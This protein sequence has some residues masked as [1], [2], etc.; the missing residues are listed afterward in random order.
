VGLDDA[1]EESAAY[2]TELTVNGSG[3]STNVIPAACRVVGERR[4]GV[5]EVGDC[6]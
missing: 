5:L 3:G 2:E 4:I 1:V 6:N